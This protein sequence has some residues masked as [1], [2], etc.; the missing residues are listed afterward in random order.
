M[1]YSPELRRRFESMSTV[2]APVGAA[3]GCAT[4]SVSAQDRSQNVWVKFIVGARDGRIEHVGYRAFGC[5]HLLAACDW[6][7]ERLSGQSVTALRHLDLTVI[8][9]EL[10]VPRVKYGKL[11]KIEDALVGCA[12]E[13]ER[14]KSAKECN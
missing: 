10:G 11:L 3:F 14:V 2:G 4:V 13:I 8:A 12:D 5:P 1:D 6:L 7:A 9:S